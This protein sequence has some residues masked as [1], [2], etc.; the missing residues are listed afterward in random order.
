[1]HELEAVSIEVG[2]IGGVVARGEVGAIRWFALVGAPSSDCSRVSCVDQFIDLHTSQRVLEIANGIEAVQER[3]IY[4]ARQ[5]A[6]LA[7]R[8]VRAFS[9][10]GPVTL[11]RPSARAQS[12]EWRP[13]ARNSEAQLAPITPC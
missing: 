3:R 4:I 9:E 13:L 5:I 2:D 8:T 7:R 10:R 11:L 12:E 6:T 1:M